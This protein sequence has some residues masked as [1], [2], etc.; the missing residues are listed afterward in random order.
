MVDQQDDYD[1]I[2]FGSDMTNPSIEKEDQN[3]ADIQSSYDNSEKWL[4]ELE[5]SESDALKATCRETIENLKKLGE[6]SK[7]PHNQLSNS[8]HVN[9][10]S[11]YLSQT[12]HLPHTVPVD[13]SS[14]NSSQQQQL[15]RNSPLTSPHQTNSPIFNAAAATTADPQMQIPPI[16]SE[17]LSLPVQQL[18]QVQRMPLPQVQMPPSLPPGANTMIPGPNYF[19]QP[20]GRPPLYRVPGPQSIHY[21]PH[22]AHL[23]QYGP[24]SYPSI[25]ALP[26]Q[27]QPQLSQQI[28]RGRHPPTTAVVQNSR[29]PRL[30]QTSS[31]PRQR[32]KRPMQQSMQVQSQNN[33]VKQRRMNG[34]LRDR[35]E[36]ANYQV[37][38][39]QKRNDELPVIQN[40]QGATTQQTSRNDSTINLTDSINLSVRQSALNLDSAIIPTNSQRKQQE[41]GQ[42]AVPQNKQ[43]KSSINE[44][45]ERPPRPPTVDLTQDSPPQMPV[46]RHDCPPRSLLTCQVCANFQNQDMLT[47]HM[48]T[49][50]TISKLHH[51]CNLCPAQY[52][53]IQALTTHKQT[54]HKKVDTVAQNRGAE[55]ALPVV[56][57]KSPH[58]L[59]RWSN[60]NIQSCIPLSQ[61]SAQIGGYFGLPIIT[62]DSA[63]N[64]STWNL[65]ALGATSILR[66]GP[67][68][69]LSNR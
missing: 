53:T 42:F 55:L 35:N 10:N 27:M 26:P 52:P 43:N 44:Q 57:L 14:T 61:L 47:Q 23:Y 45:V 1:N 65:G 6:Q 48:A 19:V 60:L 64:S 2:K 56:D 32:M 49:Y 68:K 12:S 33:T 18:A 7:T 8:L 51:R 20:P 46:V 59:N 36:D 40:V 13:T 69:H 39:Q 24:G 38:A 21:P 34:L 5:N 3:V 28:P 22:V 37:I 31:V 67:L 25:V 30:P 17:Q 41:Q 62:I 11:S 63:R 58:V 54:C 66:L 16:N 4:S 15:S 50:R 29:T 9:Q